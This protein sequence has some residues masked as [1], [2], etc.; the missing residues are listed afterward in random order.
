MTI[1]V[2]LNELKE[3]DLTPN[4]YVLLKIIKSDNLDFVYWDYAND[5]EELKLKG[6]Y[7]TDK[8]MATKKNFSFHNFILEWMKLW[9]THELPGGYRVSGNTMEVTK[10]MK[11]FLT[12]FNY[13]PDEIIEAT[14][15]YLDARKNQNWVYTKKNSKFIYDSDGSMLEQECQ[16]LLT[17]TVKPR[18]NTINL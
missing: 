9:P 6:Y 5:L 12:T 18:D 13:S 7:P 14:K 11:K 10:R 3:F 15:N 8:M 4:Q 1:T 16:A 17:G 2:N